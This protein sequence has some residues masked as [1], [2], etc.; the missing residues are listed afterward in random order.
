MSLLRQLQGITG[1]IYRKG[2]GA[3]FKQCVVGPQ[4]FHG[5]ISGVPFP[6]RVFFVFHRG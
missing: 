4:R 3:N 1:R 5:M 2:S 6:V